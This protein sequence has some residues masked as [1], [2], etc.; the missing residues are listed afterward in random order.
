ALEFYQR[1][2]PESSS[3]P[4]LRVETALAYARVGNI[5]NVFSQFTEAEEAYLG[6]I[7]L[8]K[9][10]VAEA[11]RDP[12]YRRALAWCRR[13]YSDCLEGSGRPNWE[14]EREV[15]ASLELWLGLADEFPAN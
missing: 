14:V 7:A 10:L 4:Q 8:A 5:R 3:D 9:E 2:L 15:R 12:G 1:L 11:P 6:G 13:G